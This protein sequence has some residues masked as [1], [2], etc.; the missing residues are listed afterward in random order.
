MNPGFR[1]NTVNKL[2]IAWAITLLLIPLLSVYGRRLQYL[3]RDNFTSTQLAIVFFTLSI[4]LLG[5]LFRHAVKSQRQNLLLHV[6]WTAVVFLL[7]PFAFSNVE[8][9]LHFIVFGVFGF[10]SVKIFG[11]TI[12]VLVISVVSGLD[13]CLQW[14][15]PDR[16]GDLRDVG[17]NWLAGIAGCLLALT[18]SEKNARIDSTD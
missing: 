11:A 10:F 13:E 3:V 9:R 12:A 5:L 18:V 2:Q 4:L 16:V 17:I 1:I 7:L 15:L 8:E 6:I 14:L